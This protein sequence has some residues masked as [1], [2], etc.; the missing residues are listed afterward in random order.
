MTDLLPAHGD[1]DKRNK[2]DIVVRL[3]M[4]GATYRQ[5]SAVM[6]ISKSQAQR[7]YRVATGEQFKL[8]VARHRREL[9]ADLEL[10]I[11]T[12]RPRV[13]DDEVPAHKDDV[14]AFLRANKAKA[15]LLGLEAPKATTVMGD[16]TMV[17]DNPIAAEFVADLAAW[18]HKTQ[19]ISVEG[20]VRPP[21]PPGMTERVMVEPSTNGHVHAGPHGQGMWSMIVEFPRED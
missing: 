17:Q 14:N 12:L 4:A 3:K 1:L 11:E 13:H 15:L 5:I 19:A 16:F 18:I 10:L 20:N 7:V 2:D 9:Y 8:D 6:G 21:L